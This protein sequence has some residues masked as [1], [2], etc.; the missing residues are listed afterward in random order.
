MTI[1]PIPMGTALLGSDADDVLHGTPAGDV[2]QGGA[3]N[4]QLY[5]EA[6]DDVLAGGAGSDLLDGGADTDTAAFGARRG[7]YALRVKDGHV[8]VTH[9]A[10]GDVDELH[11]IE[12]MSFQGQ[13]MGVGEV[14][15]RMYQALLQ[16]S[17]DLVELSYW[18][19]QLRSGKSLHDVAQSVVDSPEAN[20]G[21]LDD[22]YFVLALYANSL[23][24]DVSQA[25]LDYWVPQLEAGMDRAALVLTI[26]NSAE[27]MARPVTVDLTYSD[28]AVMARLYNTAFGRAPDEAGL[29]SWLWA[30][31][32]EAAIGDIADTFASLVANPAAPGKPLSDEAFIRQLF[33][34]G[35]H[36]DASAAEMDWMKGLAAAGFD[37]GQLLL[38]ISESAESIQLVGVASSDITTG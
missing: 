14:M 6:G 31:E 19:D 23:G 37:R 3:G 22:G 1:Q 24:R 25:E 7:D 21:L 4:D 10:S 11:S 29:N 15:Q 27:A 5:G 30:I 35:L 2:L 28:V 32:H 34:T 33:H 36:R 12:A 38:T 26:I 13:G 17:P 18:E 20:S 8:T 9:V 16:R